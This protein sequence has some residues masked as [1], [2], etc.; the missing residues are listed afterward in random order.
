MVRFKEGIP[1]KKS[2]KH[3][4]WSAALIASI[5]L[6]LSP[7]EHVVAK[8]IENTNLEIETNNLQAKYHSLLNEMNPADTE[9]SVDEV[10][11]IQDQLIHFLEKE[12]KPVLATAMKE[13]VSTLVELEELFASLLVVSEEESEAEQIEE[14]L[15]EIEEIPTAEEP[16]DSDV[17]LMQV[18]IV[19][20][21][22][23]SIKEPAENS[24]SYT[25]LPGDTLNK[26]AREHQVTV[27]HIAKLNNIRNVNSIRVGQVLIID[28]NRVENKLPDDLTNLNQSMT[29]NEFIDYLGGHAAVTAKEQNLYASV[30]IAQAALESGFGTSG[31]SS[32]PN[33]NLYGMKGRYE[34]ESVLM[35]TREYSTAKGWHHVDAHFKK[36]PSYLES[37]FDHSAYIR[38]GPSWAPAYYSGVWCENTTS[39]QDATAWLQ[40]RYATDPTYANKLNN[41]IEHYN[42]T[43]FDAIGGGDLVVQ[44][45]INNA[46]P[47]EDVKPSTSDQIADSTPENT[48]TAIYRV[49]SGDTLSHIAL[50][51]KMSVK[52]L[53]ELNRL[54]SDLIFV[55]QSLQVKKVL[56]ETPPTV[57]PE[58]VKPSG[59][60]SSQHTVRIGDTLS[61]I[62]RV[63]KTSVAELKKLNHLKTDTI[64]VGQ[65]LKVQ[66]SVVKPT[67]VPTPSK[68]TTSS[69][70]HHIV[71]RGD[72]LS[73]IARVH[74]MSVAQLKELNNLQADLIYIGQ[75]LKVKASLVESTPKPPPVARPSETNKTSYT[76]KRGDTLS[77]IAPQYKMSVRALKE[78]NNLQADLIFVGQKLNVHSN[79][80]VSENRRINSYQIKAGDNLSSLARRFNTSVANLKVKNNLKSDLIYVNQT[81]HI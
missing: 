53:K 20:T 78:L 14:E 16:S 73:Q 22:A 49:K 74:K 72:T 4:P 18:N 38:R 36:Y 69:S 29:Q 77:H 24:V 13:E 80:R 50:V 37:L 12:G 52:V 70:S 35:R 81:L 45:P 42:L 23:L 79:E 57:T 75:Q 10:K 41:I 71:K 44:P 55:G 3:I 65:T 34:G 39:Y 1:V 76:V 40:G 28:G 11:A 21:A 54:H 51:H 7:K 62:A 59:S 19:Q 47:E 26:I 56:V 31:L 30:M 17:E 27:D 60:S 2:K 15:V 33:H 25:V 68:P 66:A 64:Y 61:Q 5:L 63:Y 32:A 8:E 6:A 9:L 58:P 67:P 48:E 46:K 43:R